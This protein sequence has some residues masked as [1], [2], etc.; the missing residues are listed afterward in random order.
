M[1]EALRSRASI[2]ARLVVL[3]TFSS[4]VLLGGALAVFYRGV[5]RHLDD[6]HRHL[7]AEVV[8]IVRLSAPAA[9]PDVL[10]AAGNATGRHGGAS[11]TGAEKYSFR[12]LGASGSI[13]F[14]SPGIARVPEDAFAEVL[15]AAGGGTGV[16]TPWRSAAGESYLL[17][18]ATLD[19]GDAS[20]GSVTLHAALDVT[21]DEELLG[22][23]RWNGL[24]LLAAGT[25]LSSV[26]GAAIARRGLRPI[27]RLTAEMSSTSAGRLHEHLDRAAFPRELRPLAGAFDDMRH[28]LERAFADLSAYSGN[29]AHELRTPLANLCGEA[30]VAL[31]RARS[32]EEY[33]DV[34]GSSLDELR[35]LSR[36]VEALLFL[37]RADRREASAARFTVDVGAEVRT[38]VE[39]YAGV[40]DEVGVSLAATGHAVAELDAELFRRAVGNLV[41]NALRH[42][43]RGGSVTVGVAEGAGDSV[44][45]TVADDGH[46]IAAA[47]LPHVFERFYRAPG[48]RGTTVPGSG[49][50]LSIVRSIVDLHGGRVEIASVPGAG[51]RVT[52][53]FPARH[54]AAAQQR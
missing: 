4:A 13:L 19:G 17:A 6:E 26:A 7:L 47:H 9:R 14:A 22:D 30:E 53:H 46:G 11:R 27:E 32:A 12:L 39:F 10:A 21:P 15:G 50:G 45:V 40:A 33:R 31:L 18:V 2:G 49:L 28:R 54:A 48:E 41:A 44:E 52:M 25:V 51:T 23:V 24:L 36:L 8:R 3:F 38:V 16:G 43:D 34:L 20:G 37:A 1:V 42:V 35:R 5:A 29:L